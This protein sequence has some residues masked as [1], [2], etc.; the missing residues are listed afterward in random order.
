MRQL[1]YHEQKL[2]KKTNFLEWKSDSTHAMKV[3]QRFHL[4]NREEYNT[5]DKLIGQ[6]RHLANQLSKL[7]RED[8]YRTHMTMRMLKKLQRM[9]V[10]HKIEGLSQVEHVTVSAVAKRRLA[11]LLVH[12]KMAPRLNDAHELIMQGHV[13]V[14]PHVVTDPAMLVPSEMESYITW[15][16]GRMR[17]KVD[18]FHGVH[19]DI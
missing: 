15:R 9:G 10:I 14:G 17:E 12:L 5:Y 18:R 8:P 4:K 1:K 3:I 7:E 13:R 2:L 11:C 19:E 16:Q 6:M